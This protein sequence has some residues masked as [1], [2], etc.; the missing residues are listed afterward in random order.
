[1]AHSYP[2]LAAIYYPILTNFSKKIKDIKLGPNERVTYMTT[3]PLLAAL[4]PL[5]PSTI[6]EK[7]IKVY[8]GKAEEG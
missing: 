5:V 7:L 8:V 3:P 6:M 1:M 4:M 2:Q